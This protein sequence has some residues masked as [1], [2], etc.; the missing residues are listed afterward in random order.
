MQNFVGYYPMVNLVSSLYQVTYSVD[1]RIAERTWLKWIK[2]ACVP[3]GA[4]AMVWPISQCWVIISWFKIY[5][6]G[7][8]CLP[9][10]TEPT[11]FTLVE[12]FVCHI[13]RN[14]QNL[15]LWS[16]LFAIYYATNKIYSC[17]VICLPSITQPTRF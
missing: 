9:Y 16:H 3:A 2:S 4:E 15:L 11:R 17:E 12:S 6:C 8:I 5:S 14:Q 1:W 13:L 7:V 10:I